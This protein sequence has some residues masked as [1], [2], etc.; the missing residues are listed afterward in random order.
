MIEEMEIRIRQH[1]T[2][3]A[4]LMRRAIEAKRRADRAECRSVLLTREVEAL[5]RPALLWSSEE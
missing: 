1:A 2:C 3:S 4:G 5:C